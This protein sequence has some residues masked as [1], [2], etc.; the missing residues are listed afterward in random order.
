MCPQGG[1]RSIHDGGG[2]GPMSDVFLGLKI[3]T[4]A[5]FLIK[6]LLHIFLR[7]QSLFDFIKQYSGV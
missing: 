6:D 4:L 5:M 1:T 2:G 7:S 3:Y